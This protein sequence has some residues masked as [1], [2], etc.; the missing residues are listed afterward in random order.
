[1]D[2]QLAYNGEGQENPD[3]CTVYELK[4][5]WKTFYEVYSRYMTNARRNVTS[6][7]K[8]VK[9]TEGAPPKPSAPAKGPA[10]PGGDIRAAEPFQL[11][12]PPQPVQQ[13]QPSP[14]MT[15]EP[16]KIFADED[17]KHDIAK[18]MA[19][20]LSGLAT[21]ESELRR[22]DLTTAMRRQPI[23]AVLPNMTV[24][25][26]FDELYIFIAQLRQSM[27]GIDTDFFSNKW[28]FKYITRILDDRVLSMLMQKPGQFLREPISIN[29]N[30][31]TLL[32]SSFTEFDAA[33]NPASRI[34]IVFE[35]PVVDV[36]ADMAAFTLA[37]QEVQRLGYRVCLDGLTAASF[38]SISREKLGLDIMKVQWNADVQSELNSKENKDLADAVQHAGSNRVILCRCDNRSAVEYGHALGISLFQG[39]FIDSVLDPTSKVNN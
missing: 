10:A 31:E 37:R 2:D 36:Y 6:L 4:H 18:K 5:S 39:R 26:V 17:D 1:M 38:A 32:S 14:R 15:A 11:N 21:I 34:S 22:I 7:G 9:P 13:T 35:I 28:L 25:R 16:K 24:R 29:I 30:V 23:C 27:G 3:L 12:S 33:I 20:S 8:P 19:H